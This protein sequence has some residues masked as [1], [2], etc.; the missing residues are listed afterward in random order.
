MD[1]TPSLPERRRR[2]GSPVARRLLFAFGVV[3]I[4]GT[5]AVV[6][7]AAAALLGWHRTEMLIAAALGIGAMLALAAVLVYRLAAEHGVTQR[8]L[9]DAEARIG[10]VLNSAMD[11]II[12]LDHQQR[13]VLFNDAAEQ[14]FRW[15]RE[16]VLGKTLDMLLPQRFRD[17]HR[18][19]IEQFGST[20]VTSRRMGAS[21][22][23]TGVRA[24]GEEFPVEAAISQFGE[25]EGR[26]YTVILRDITARVDAEGSLARGEARLRGILDSA[27]DAIITVDE[28]QRVIL[29]NA[30][31][32]AVFGCPREEALGAPLAWFIPERFRAEHGEHMRRFGA[33]DVS[34]RRMGAQRI[35]TGLRRNGEEF[36]IDASIS[37]ITDAGHKYYTVILRD[38]TERVRAEQALRRSKEELREFAAAANQLREQEQRRI[39]RELHDELAQALTGLK[40]DVAWIKDKLPGQP[41]VAAKLD[42]MEE[43]L[44]G[45]VAA[46]RRISSALRP[47]MLDDL[48]LVP[49]T[50]WL[51]QNFTERTGINCRL[52][53]DADQEFSDPHATTVFRILQE[54]LTNIAKHAQARNVDVKL[55][56]HNGEIVLDVRDDGTGFSPQNPRKPNSYGLIGMRERA[57]LLGGQVRVE[58]VPGSGT[59]IHVRL[60]IDE[61]RQRTED[62][63]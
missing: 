5:S 9:H 4:V 33:G 59:T 49:A 63:R 20:G 32:E 52:A 37:Y 35:V 27:M 60:P 2:G 57:Y 21:A 13:V 47:L 42:A 36:P 44:D 29:F 18:K 28:R 53:A 61:T 62:T 39:A 34:A 3:L 43:L 55:A 48:G 56:Q 17:I 8:S 22:V 11:A 12:T 31:A 19:H 1:Q 26:L 24:D 14:V 16:A 46:T 54:S 50:E 51:V 58:S 15:P 25:G 40:M 7:A 10:G 6:L 41:S 38:V 45:T 30:A 23:L